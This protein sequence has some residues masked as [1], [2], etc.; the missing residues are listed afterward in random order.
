MGVCRLI[1]RIDFEPCFG[2]MDRYGTLA[3]TMAREEDGKTKFFTTMQDGHPIREIKGTF[4]EGSLRRE[5]SVSLTAI[6]IDYQNLEGVP[7]D[8]IREDTTFSRLT[9]LVTTIRKDFGIF[10]ELRTGLRLFYVNRV[11]NAERAKMTAAF[12]QLIDTS[13]WEAVT[14]ELAEPSDAG[15]SFS[16]GVEGEPQYVTRFGPFMGLSEYDKYFQAAHADASKKLLEDANFIFDLDQFQT[17]TKLGPGLQWWKPMLI[18]AN[19]L[20]PRVEQQI[21]NV[22]KGNSP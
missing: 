15:V 22:I 18:T 13:L 6:I 12:R 19:K 14:G 1:M 3:Q 10:S 9:D 5:L 20:I 4:N 21:A 11:T 2:I 7:L 17:R 8:G 16:G